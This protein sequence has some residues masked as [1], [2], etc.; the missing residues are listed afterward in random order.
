[1][2]Y[3]TESGVGIGFERIGSYSLYDDFCI[4]SETGTN[5]EPD[6][7]CYW[8]STTTLLWTGRKAF[9]SYYKNSTL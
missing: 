2:R 7:I 8:T 1:M 5:L 6:L 3:L 9:H 4:A